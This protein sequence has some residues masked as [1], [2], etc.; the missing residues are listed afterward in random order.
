MIW[1]II[2][3]AAIVIGI[4]LCYFGSK[5]YNDSCVF[6]GGGMS[7]L[8]FVILIF[9]FLTLAGIKAEFN[10]FINRY[11]YTKN[12]VENYCYGDY[13]NTFELTNQ[14]IEINNTIAEHKA[15]CDNPWYNVWYSKDIGELEPLFL[16]MSKRN[17]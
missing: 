12:I 1:I 11:E 8:F 5:F 6:I 9:M 10:T 2:T 17:D 15:K 14:I 4:A 7:I 3:I 13:G 16:P